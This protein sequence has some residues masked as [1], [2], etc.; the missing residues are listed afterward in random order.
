MMQKYADYGRTFR[1]L[2]ASRPRRCQGQAIRACAL[3]AL[4][5]YFTL[6]GGRNYF[7]RHDVNAQNWA[8]KKKGGVRDVVYRRLQRHI[9][10]GTRFSAR[11]HQSNVVHESHGQ[12]LRNSRQPRRAWFSQHWGLR[13]RG[14]VTDNPTEPNPGQSAVASTGPHYRKIACRNV[15]KRSCRHISGPRYEPRLPSA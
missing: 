13:R 4:S 11:G 10:A 3:L 7:S 14:R 12:K 2:P 8:K 1:L 15:L 9:P 6:S 5:S